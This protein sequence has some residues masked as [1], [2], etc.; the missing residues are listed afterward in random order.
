MNGPRYTIDELRRLL[1]DRRAS[2]S[3]TVVSQLTSDDV[4]EAAMFQLKDV[5][6][7]DGAVRLDA[8]AVRALI[9]EWL[10][11]AVAETLKYAVEELEH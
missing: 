8:P 7:A 4:L 1:Q 3:E 9:G 10:D 11:T 2:I 5:V 6:N